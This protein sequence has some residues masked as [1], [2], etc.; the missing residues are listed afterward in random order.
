MTQKK[1]QVKVKAKPKAK[2]KPRMTRIRYKK[3]VSPF[4]GD[5]SGLFLPWMV[6]VMVFLAALTASLNFALHRGLSDW[7]RD[8]SSEITLQVLPGENKEKESRIIV[9]YLNASKEYTKVYKLGEIEIE[10]LLKPYLGDI[11]EIES[12]I[13]P[14]MIIL[15]PKKDNALPNSLKSIMA[16]F[17]N[18][19]VGLQ[20]EW[21]G[22]MK[23]FIKSLERLA[24][25]ILIL[26]FFSM[27]FI[28]VYAVKTS[29][30]V[31][32][33]AINLLHLIGARDDYIAK[34]FAS[35][36]GTLA[37]VG[38]IV[39]AGMAIPFI[40]IIRVLMGNFQDGIFKNIRFT[41]QDDF[42]IALLALF[43]AAFVYFTTYLTVKQDLL[44]RT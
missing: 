11:K 12:D 21:L 17:K 24:A 1:E 37:L 8:I 13:L 18:V 5:S 33:K 9:D 38:S 16:K 30:R 35:R 44:R 42:F 26:V 34:K 4:A 15:V 20:Q 25:M 23:I 14:D 29:L 39:G 2:A 19:K 7:Y 31:H 32:A 43:T 41:N 36:N 10:R 6:M 3:P 27:I 28:V 40:H 22:H